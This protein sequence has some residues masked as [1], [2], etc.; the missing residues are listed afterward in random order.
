M[1]GDESPTSSGVKRKGDDSNSNAQSKVKINTISQEND[2]ISTFVVV[3]GTQRKMRTYNPI[4][5]HRN[6]VQKFGTLK[7]VRVLGSGDLKIECSNEK[8]V[9][10]LLECDDIGDSTTN[11][12]VKTELFVNNDQNTRVVISD[13]PIDMADNELLDAL[14]GQRVVFVKRLNRKIEG[15]FVQSKSV[16]ICFNTCIVPSIV[17][18][19]YMRFR[20]RVYN[21]P[22]IR[23]FNC[24]RFGH[25]AKNCRCKVRCAKCG[26]NHE[27]NKCD[28]ET[29]RCCNCGQEHSAAYGG[30]EVYKRERLIQKTMA[31]TKLPYEEAKNHIKQTIS[32]TAQFSANDFPALPSK[33]PFQGSTPVLMIRKSKDILSSDKSS[34]QAPIIGQYSR[35]NSKEV[36]EDKNAP[37]SLDPIHFFAFIAEVIKN[38]LEVSQSGKECDVYAIVSMSAGAQFGFDVDAGNLKN[39]IKQHSTKK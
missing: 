33:V 20:T 32:E 31:S 21:P 23:C 34:Q 2:V 39:A 17:T 30:C 22:P 27:Y 11:I 38:T 3:R 12:P 36:N 8:Q 35:P 24:N 13:V 5:I 1:D 18:I 10:L 15:K 7:A 14:S 37:I 16:L 6:L 26:R 29:P 19:G 4:V 9:K 25:V 28:S